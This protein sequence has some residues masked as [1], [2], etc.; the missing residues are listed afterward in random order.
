MPPTSRSF[1]NTGTAADDD[2]VVD[3]DVVV[4]S[5]ATSPLAPWTISPPPPP[6][7]PPPLDA[8]REDRVRGDD[9]EDDH[10]GPSIVAVVMLGW[11]RK[12][13]RRGTWVQRW[14]V[15]DS[16]GGVH[17][18]RHPPS[19]PG[20]STGSKPPS[21]RQRANRVVTLVGG[22]TACHPLRTI[23]LVERGGKKKTK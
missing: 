5:A 22:G 6:P 15:L 11:L 16:S 9:V 10:D 8:L 14:F 19:P 12:W 2:A 13:T 18:S 4:V 1:D 17:Y 7:P 23:P 21:R 20:S 3:A